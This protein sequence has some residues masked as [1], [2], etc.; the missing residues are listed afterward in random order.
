[1][2]FTQW[3]VAGED[4]SCRPVAVESITREDE[5]GWLFLDR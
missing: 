3:S 2:L 1:M 5:D 4:L